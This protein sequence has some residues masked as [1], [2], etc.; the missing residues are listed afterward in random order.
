MLSEAVILNLSVVKH[1]QY[2]WTLKAVILFSE[3]AICFS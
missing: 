2:L 1:D 3:V